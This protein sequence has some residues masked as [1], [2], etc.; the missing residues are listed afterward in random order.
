MRR[1]VTATGEISR[2]GKPSILCARPQRA[3]NRA[4]MNR[5]DLFGKPGSGLPARGPPDDDFDDATSPTL[6]HPGCLFATFVIERATA[7]WCE[8]QQATPAG[9]GFG[10]AE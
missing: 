7:G 4:R 10:A 8:V 5:E 9:T 3:A 1:A 6:G 2:I